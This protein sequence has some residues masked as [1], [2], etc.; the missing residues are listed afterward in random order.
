MGLWNGGE[1]G[2]G[3]RVA[4]LGSVF[5]AFIAFTLPAQAARPIPHRVAPHHAP[6][7][8]VAARHEVVRHAP[9]HHVAVR[10]QPVRHEPV[11]HVAARHETP[12]HTVIRRTVVRHTAAR[13]E[14]SRHEVARLRR[15]GHPVA[16][17]RL[18][19][20][21][22]SKVR[23]SAASYGGI[24]CVPFA[25]AAS[26]IELKGDARNW[27]EAAAGIYAR[28][29]RPEPG[30]V[31]NFRGTGRMRLGHVAVVTRVINA[32]E[33][34]I[35]HANWSGPGQ[36]RGQV[37]RG[38]SVVDVSPRNDWTQVRVA[39]GHGDS[40]GSVYPTYGFIYDRPDR[41]IMVANTLAP[42]HGGIISA[43]ASKVPVEVA[44]APLRGRGSVNVLD[45]P[46]RSLR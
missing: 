28:G 45:A 9:V 14:P 11:R 10:H 13:H 36:R 15:S 27:W 6:I 41:G 44:D 8:H 35:D 16:G 25:R 3:A 18:S 2:V 31:L 30:A 37:A 29:A 33:I 19:R 17:K 20:H 32:R 4:L 43:A 1:T 24:S 12:H 7:H 46:T 34:E 5:A 26:G 42:A 38:V 40:F 23:Y 22:I 21:L 39:L